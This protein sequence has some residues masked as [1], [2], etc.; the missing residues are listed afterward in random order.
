MK[1]EC[2]SKRKKQWN[3]TWCY[4]NDDNSQHRLHCTCR[5]LYVGTVVLLH[6]APF[7]CIWSE[8]FRPIEYQLL[9]GN[10]PVPVMDL[11]HAS[12]HT[13]STSRVSIGSSVFAGRGPPRRSLAHG[14]NQQR[15]AVHN[16]QW[17]TTLRA[18]SVATAH[19][20]YALC[21]GNA[22]WK[23]LCRVRIA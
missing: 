16:V 19:I 3:T 17:Q 4:S 14:G 22:G 1:M 12:L 10:M 11:G 2:K 20:I 23:Y 13:P 6:S 8:Y 18:T 7:S 9:F 5:P 21:A 15:Q